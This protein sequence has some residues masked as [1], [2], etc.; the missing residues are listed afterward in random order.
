MKQPEGRSKFS[1]RMSTATEELLCTACQEKIEDGKAMRVR[2]RGREREIEIYM[3]VVQD[4]RILIFE[5]NC[6]RFDPAPSA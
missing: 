1:E 4:L 6:E 5:M 3:K 2:E